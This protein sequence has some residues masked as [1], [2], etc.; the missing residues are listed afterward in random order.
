[1]KKRRRR[2]KNYGNFFAFKITTHRKENKFNNK[3]L[4]ASVIVFVFLLLRWL[5]SFLSVKAIKLELLHA[6][7]LFD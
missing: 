7:K 4:S 3:L 6:V 5:Q 2:K 1:V